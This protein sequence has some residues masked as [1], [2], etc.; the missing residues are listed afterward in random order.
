MPTKMLVCLF[1]LNMRNKSPNIFSQALENVQYS[2]F[3]P[4]HSPMATS[5]WVAVT[6]IKKDFPGLR[7]TKSRWFSRCPLRDAVTLLL[8]HQKSKYFIAQRLEGSGLC[9]SC[10]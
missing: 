6:T 1:L 3:F 5:L 8:G 7:V 4:F 10:R 2:I 9:P